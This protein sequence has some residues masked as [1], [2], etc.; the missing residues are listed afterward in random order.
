MK[1]VLSKLAM[2]PWWR[3][4][5][6]LAVQSVW[7]LLYTLFSIEQIDVCVCV[8]VCVSLNVCYYTFAVVSFVSMLIYSRLGM[9]LSRLSMV[10]LK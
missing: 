8:C 6:Y 1:D 5:L 7:K 3:P 9:A 2:L 4:V 10:S